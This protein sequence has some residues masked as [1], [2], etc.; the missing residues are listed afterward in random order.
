MTSATLVG[1]LVTA[2]LLGFTHGIEPDHIAGI[3]ALAGETGGSRLSAVAGACFSLGHVVLVVLW[4]G[5]VV[6]FDGL[7][8]FPRS[9][10]RF[11][12]VGAALVLAGLGTV[13]VL[14]GLRVVARTDAHSPGRV[15]HGH[16]HMHLPVAGIGEHTDDLGSYIQTGLVGALFTLSPPLSM[17][18]FTGT[19]FPQYGSGIVGLAVAVYAVSITFTMSAIGAGVGATF[20]TAHSLDARAYG[21]IR[22]VGGI[23]VV[24]LAVG[25]LGSTLPAV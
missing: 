13:M 25:M 11:G 21:A 12:T 24:A 22:T 6:V 23:V 2:G 20:G 18:A 7:N 1:A 19:V 5:V 3:S 15:P 16:S 8:A 9:L 14:G 4:L 10:D 17:I